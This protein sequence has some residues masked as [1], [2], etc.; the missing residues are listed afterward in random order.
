MQYKIHSLKEEHNAGS[1]VEYF[2]CR[3]D[4][5]LGGIKVNDDLVYVKKGD[6]AVSTRNYGGKILDLYSSPDKKPPKTFW[7]VRTRDAMW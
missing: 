3:H 1:I 4:K 6:I 5:Y 7:M 2:F